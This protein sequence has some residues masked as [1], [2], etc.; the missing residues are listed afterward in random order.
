VIPIYPSP[1]IVFC[2]L[3]FRP[4]A[5]QKGSTFH[6]WKDIWQDEAITHDSVLARLRVGEVQENPGTIRSIQSVTYQD[7]E[8]EGSQSCINRLH[9]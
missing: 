6:A 8:F 4:D 5:I 9:G 1:S 3:S 7:N 2:D